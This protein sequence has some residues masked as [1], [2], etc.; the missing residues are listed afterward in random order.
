MTA[1]IVP[2]HKDKNNCKTYIGVRLNRT[3][4]KVHGRIVIYLEY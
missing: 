4:G 2:L 1:L 3:V